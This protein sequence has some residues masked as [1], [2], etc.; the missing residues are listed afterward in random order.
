MHGTTPPQRQD[1]THVPRHDAATRARTHATN[2]AAGNTR[3][4]HGQRSAVI[5]NHQNGRHP[6][7]P[8]GAKPDLLS[9]KCIPSRVG[10]L[11]D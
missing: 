2:D 3:P 5:M 10:E 1:A 11:H 4:M 9:N 6:Q 8:I 7:K